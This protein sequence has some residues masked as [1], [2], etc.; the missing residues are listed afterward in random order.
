M[1]AI[2]FPNPATQNPPNTFSP[3]ST[4]ARTLNGITYIWNGIGWRVTNRSGEGQEAVVYVTEEAPAAASPGDL[5]WDSGAAASLFI[6]YRDQ[7]ST[8]WVPATP[9]TDNWYINGGELVPVR[10]A[11]D[12]KVSGTVTSNNQVLTLSSGNLDV[13]DR[14]KKA[15]DALKALKTSAAAAA[16][17]AALKS[18][19]ASALASV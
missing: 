13:G 3:T 14:L 17:F 19:I 15:D 11:V 4:P 10:G 16:D 2:N 8:Q 12:V 1:A 7:D 5:W 18:A 6:Y 9:A